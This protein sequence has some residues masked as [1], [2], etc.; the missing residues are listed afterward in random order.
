MRFTV[1]DENDAVL[2][3]ALQHEFLRC[4]DAFTEFRAYASHA[5]LLGDNPWLSFKTYN[6]YC[7]F[8]HHLYEFMAGALIRERQD[9]TLA[10]GDKVA[11]EVKR[12]ISQHAQ[13]ILT[14]RRE[15]I[16]NKT[17][18]SWENALSAYP[19]KIPPAFA[20]DFRNCRNKTTGHV[21]PERASF[22]LSEFYDRYHLYLHLLYQ[23]ALAWWNIRGKDFPDL[24]EITDFSVLIRSRGFDEIS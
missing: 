19:E 12:F 9:T 6:A 1:G 23:D 3:V 7:R 2:C 21:S 15:A 17:A 13:R 8:I 22:N 14:N 10:K 4:H 11:I 5:A 24:K 20:D 16:K 18:P